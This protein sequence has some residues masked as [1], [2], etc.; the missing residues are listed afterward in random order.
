MKI[1]KAA[2]TT[3]AERRDRSYGGEVAV[4]S[5]SGDP[6]P[7]TELTRLLGNHSRDVF[8]QV[9][10]FT[11]N[12]L[13][14][15]DLLSDAN[16]NSQ[17]YSAGM[18]VASLQDVMNAI[19]RSRKLPLSSAGGSTQEIYGSPPTVL[20]TV[21]SKLWEAGDNADEIRATDRPP[22]SGRD[23]TRRLGCAA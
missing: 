17:I 6:L 10:A 1:R 19:E 5:A 23:R 15:D 22:A 12:E 2:C 18:G 9:F 11:L 7:E 3:F 21:D 13:Y 14:S 16:V 20:T 8:E 4:T